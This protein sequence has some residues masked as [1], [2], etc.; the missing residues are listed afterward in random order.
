[1]AL[2]RPFGLLMEGLLDDPSQAQG[3]I[4]VPE[5]A[6]VRQPVAGAKER[7]FFFKGGKQNLAESLDEARAEIVESFDKLELVER[8]V[9]GARQKVVK[10]GIFIVEG[11]YQRSDVK[12]ANQRTYSRKIWERILGDPNGPVQQLVKARGMIGHLEHPADGRTDGKQGALLN[13]E[14][15]LREDGVVWGKSELLD[16]PHGLILQEYTRKGVRWGVSSRGNGSV[17]S[18]GKV[19][20]SDYQLVTFDAVMNPSTPGAYPKLTDATGTN[21]SAKD[22]RLSKDSDER[23]LAQLSESVDE[24]RVV[25]VNG[26]DETSRVG[27]ALA[28]IQTLERTNQ[29]AASLAKPSDK[30]AEMQGWLTGQL[31]RLMEA[32]LPDLDAVLE[33]V[34]DDTTTGQEAVTQATEMVRSVQ[35][36]LDAALDEAQQTRAE[37]ATVD[38]QLVAARK[39]LGATRAQLQTA[40]AALSETRASLKI[41]ESMLAEATEVNRVD[42][43]SEEIDRAI[44]TL[45]ALERYRPKLAEATSI[46]QLHGMVTVLS[47]HVIAESPRASGDSRQSIPRPTLP[48]GLAV[49]SEKVGP[50]KENRSNPSRPAELAAKVVLLTEGR[51]T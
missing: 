32:T 18:S 41:A 35:R 8:D 49:A 23:V 29:L 43:L 27:H 48:V 11:P 19:N 46:D 3:C 45:P 12:N 1:M 38:A 50:V 51:K 39:E 10:D 17:D 42:S 14:L 34:P 24:L 26:L 37:K 47:E 30:A 4:M 44:K 22:D 28:L 6:Y 9:N 7:V 15:K 16:T 5:V 2:E 21:E 33:S 25:D 36:R 40:E 20:E 13:T 31:K